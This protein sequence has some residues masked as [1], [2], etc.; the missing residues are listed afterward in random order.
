MIPPWLVFQ[1]RRRT[2]AILLGPHFTS[3]V[4]IVSK[5]GPAVNR[6]LVDPQSGAGGHIWSPKRV[7]RSSR[8]ARRSDPETRE[9]F[10]A[11]LRDA[12]S[13][14]SAVSATIRTEATMARCGRGNTPE[15]VMRPRAS[16]RRSRRVEI[17]ILRR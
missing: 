17:P 6:N 10:S 8:P 4:D 14:T 13:G 15:G 16:F 11:E 9:S 3:A 12:L 1:V 5:P 2:S 7:A